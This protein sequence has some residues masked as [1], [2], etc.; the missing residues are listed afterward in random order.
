MTHLN[1]PT[2]LIAASVHPSITEEQISD[3]VDQF[4]AVIRSDAQLGPIFESH[5]GNNW[6]THLAKMNKFW[7]SIL[8]KSREYDGRP[9][10]MHQKIEGLGSLEFEIWLAHF[11]KVAIQIMHPE[12]ADITIELAKRVATSLW[13][14]RFPD[15]NV[16]PPQWSPADTSI[17]ELPNGNS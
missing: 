2:N 11:S 16:S 5:I 8:L 6:D 12:A 10:P 14:S 13:L 3:L 1:H 9:V 17:S 15:P 7:R 4:Y